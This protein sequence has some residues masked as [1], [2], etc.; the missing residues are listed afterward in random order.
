MSRP[1]TC[2]AC[3]QRPVA[4]ARHSTCYQCLPGGPVTPP[5]CR[6]CRSC[7]LYYSAGLCQRCHRL[8]PQVVG[9]C[10]DCYGWGVTRTTS[11][12][13][14]GCRGLRR[15]FPV[16]AQCL[17]CRRT[18]AVNAEGFCRLCW[19]QAAMVRRHHKGVSVLEANRHGQQLF[20]VGLFHLQPAAPPTAPR[21]AEDPGRRAYPVTH[22]QLML[23]DLPRDLSHGR[24]RQLPSPPDPDFT[25]LLDQAAVGHATRH[26]WSK[27]RLTEAQQ[28]IRVLLALQDTPGAAI[29]ASEVA[30]LGQIPLSVQ[31]VL[32]VLASAGMLHDNREPPVV[33]WFSR[34]AAGLPDQMAEELRTWFDVLRLGST[35][36]PRSR[37]R[38]A[39]T[40]RLRISYAMPALRSWAAAGH[41]SLREIAR[42]HI[43]QALP[44]QGSDRSLTAQALRGLF[45]LLKARRMVFVNPTT[46]I[47]VSAPETRTPLPAE[48]AVLRQALTSD[49]P[50]R[51]V[52]A[53]LTSFHA[54][55]NGQLRALLLSDVRDGRLH[56]DGRTI[57]LARPARDRVTS[58]LDYR[59]ACWPDT[60]NPHLLVNTQ[61]AVRNGPVS[62]WWVNKTLG[63]PVRAVRE[64]RILHETIATQGDIR[65]LC[66]LFGLSVK[67]AARYATAVTGPALTDDSP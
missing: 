48:V 26:G 53:A 44:A 66:D 32:D 57:L 56:L 8:A 52:I 39:V 1:R 24:H 34:Q 9:S 27:T 67:G 29:Q 65:R 59:A 64:D 22:R 21:R 2:P 11:W 58:W 54:L 55:R 43:N 16:P 61:T 49:D 25:A 42:D 41:E 33:A 62:H 40:I 7:E 37:A 19:R 46:H 30:R 13:C 45:R 50:A 12:L 63:L 14:E 20:I 3:G 5:P 23:F 51:A 60:T 6:K 4:T 36:Y 10:I 38:A 47:R 28:A 35:T 31:P 17:S 18:I 15:R